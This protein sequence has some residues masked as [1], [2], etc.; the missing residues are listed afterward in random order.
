MCFPADHPASLGLRYGAD[1]SIR[2]A[3]FILV[4]DCDVPWIPTQ[5]KP[6]ADA[7]IVHIDVDPLKQQMPVF[8][9]PAIA[10]YRADAA[11]S[12]RQLHTYLTSHPAHSATLSSPEYDTRWANLRKLHQARHDKIASLG[13]LPSDMSATLNAPVLTA[14]VR[15]ACPADTIW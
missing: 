10:R 5:C 1:D 12:F 3:D 8:Y 6:K 9:I 2:T 7:T 11:T 4:V 13:T 15:K 14:Q